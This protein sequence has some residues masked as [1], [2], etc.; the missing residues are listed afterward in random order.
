[1]SNKLIQNQYFPRDTD[2]GPTSL[3][4]LTAV[5]TEKRNSHLHLRK[6]S[7]DK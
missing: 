4:V 2:I 7:V 3:A 5:I 1:M 6:Y